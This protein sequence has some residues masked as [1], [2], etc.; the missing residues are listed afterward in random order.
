MSFSTDVNI[1]LY[2]VNQDSEFHKKAKRFVEDKASGTET[3]I[4]PWPVIHAFLRISTH[5]G[6]L[7]RPLSPLQATSIIEQLLELPHVHLISETDNLWPYYKK[8]ILGGH[9]RG[10][11]ITDALIVALLKENGVSTIFTADRDFLRFRGIR[12]INPLS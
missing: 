12:A 10:G 5:G 6:I 3:W 2:A 1:L 4:M 8:E 11:A 7:P 9:L